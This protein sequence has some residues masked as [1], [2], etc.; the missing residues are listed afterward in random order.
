MPVWHVTQRVDSSGRVIRVLCHD[1]LPKRQFLH[2]YVGEIMKNS[3]TY[4]LEF[5]MIAWFPVLG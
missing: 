1:D 3:H 4:F 2:R 5:Y